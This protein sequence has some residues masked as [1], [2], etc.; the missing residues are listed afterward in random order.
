MMDG[1][2]LYWIVSVG[3]LGGPL[4]EFNARTYEVYA[5]DVGEAANLGRA[6]F[7][8]EMREDLERDLIAYENN[9]GDRGYKPALHHFHSLDVRQGRQRER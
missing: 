7:E 8:R 4:G 1:E 5:A 6:A 9:K 3:G 2:K